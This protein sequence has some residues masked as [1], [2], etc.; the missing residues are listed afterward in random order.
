MLGTHCNYFTDSKPIEN[1]DGEETY[2]IHKDGYAVP[3]SMNV[4]PITNEDGVVIGVV[5]VFTDKI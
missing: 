3:I 5:K 2:L 1:K 4:S